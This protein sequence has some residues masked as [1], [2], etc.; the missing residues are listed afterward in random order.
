MKANVLQLAC[1]VALLYASSNLN[2][3]TP[4]SRIWRTGTKQTALLS[5]LV[6]LEVP[7]AT[8]QLGNIVR[9]PAV[10]GFSPNINA[11]YESHFGNIFTYRVATLQNLR[12]FGFKI[13]RERVIF[14]RIIEIES[15]TANGLRYYQRVFWTTGGVAVVT[16]TAR[17]ANWSHSSVTQMIDAMKR[18]DVA[19]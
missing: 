7:V 2:A 10:N 8:T 12:A 11:L 19:R 18:A 15:T 5:G 6:W 3:Q 16:A 9:W 4:D 13:L 1:I 14:N 17:N